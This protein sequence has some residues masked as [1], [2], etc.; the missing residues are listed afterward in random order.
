MDTS[1]AP[2]PLTTTKTIK[3]FLQLSGQEARQEVNISQEATAAQLKSEFTRARSMEDDKVRL[4]FSGKYLED[5]K[6]L[7]AEGIRD[8]VVVH[9]VEKNLTAEACSREEEGAGEAVGTSLAANLHAVN[10]SPVEF[11]NLLIRLDAI[12]SRSVLGREPLSPPPVNPPSDPVRDAAAMSSL[13]TRPVYVACMIED[14]RAATQQLDP[15]FVDNGPLTRMLRNRDNIL[16]ELGFARAS[17]VIAEAAAED[18]SDMN[19][20]GDEV[21]APPASISDDNAAELRYREQLARLNA[22]GFVDNVANAAALIEARG[23]IHRAVL[24]LAH[25]EMY[26]Y[27]SI[28]NVQQYGEGDWAERKRRREF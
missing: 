13:V 1:A 25:R 18:D 19:D 27:N 28:F 20:D 7:A 4:I 15:L 24:I 21:M 8:G 26:E 3:I 17:Q 11:L 23:D 9:V 5:G 12:W 16:R 6:T 14:M 10:S 22:V 2:A